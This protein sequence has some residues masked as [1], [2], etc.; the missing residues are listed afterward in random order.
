MSGKQLFITYVRLKTNIN[1]SILNQ[2]SVL[3]R[4]INTST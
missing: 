4:Y 3:K 1:C 2:W